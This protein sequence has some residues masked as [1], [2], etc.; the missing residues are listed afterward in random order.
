MEKIKGFDVRGRG[1]VLAVKSARLRGHA[2]PLA[3]VRV[4]LRAVNSAGVARRLRAAF[5]GYLVTDVE[6]GY[7]FR[8]RRSKYAADLDPLCL[9]DF[10]SLD[11]PVFLPAGCCVD[12]S[13]FWFGYGESQQLVVRRGAA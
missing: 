7:P 11:A 5:A 3:L 8:N 6:A 12:L 13:P 10:R 4:Q 2:A 1:F 9:S